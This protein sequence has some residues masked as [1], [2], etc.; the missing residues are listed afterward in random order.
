VGLVVCK[1]FP[2][3]SGAHH[4]PNNRPENKRNDAR[5]AN[6]VWRI[7]VIRIEPITNMELVRSTL[8]TPH[9]WDA[10]ADDGFIKPEDFHPVP[11]IGTWWLGA[12][13]EAEYLGLFPIYTINMTVCEA[14]VALLKTCGGIRAKA[15]GEALKLWVWSNTN[16]KRIITSVPS[17][18]RL[19]L[20]YAKLAG[21]KEFGLNPGSW[22]KNGQTHD[23]IMLGVG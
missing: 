14:H 3:Q 2:N 20:R 1:E 7:D 17:C 22:Q 19:G 10:M 8:T 16:F 11:L 15:A 9:I 23:L 4:H 6:L 18:N 13:D 5:V 12:W 21:L